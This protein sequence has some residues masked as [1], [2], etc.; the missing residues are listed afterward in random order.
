MVY[1]GTYRVPTQEVP[2]TK[3]MEPSF[4][5]TIDRGL[6]NRLRTTR[7]QCCRN[8]V[9]KP[10]PSLLTP[11]LT[12]FLNCHPSSRGDFHHS[13]ETKAPTATRAHM[14]RVAA[15][16]N[17]YIYIYITYIYI[18]IELVYV[19]VCCY[20][21]AVETFL[22]I[23]LSEFHVPLPNDKVMMIQNIAVDQRF[24]NGTQGRLL[25]WHPSATQSKSK[26]LPAYCQELLARFCKESAL[27]K[28]ELMPGACFAV[29]LKRYNT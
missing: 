7:P 26:A 14:M 9:A 27:S 21:L 13:L 23:L 11:S 5:R 15:L 6:D 25:H 10:P 29:R 2:N 1:G 28:T 24:A 17:V 19:P 12:P 16:E 3:L 4:G 20:S 8:L 22:C 18:Y